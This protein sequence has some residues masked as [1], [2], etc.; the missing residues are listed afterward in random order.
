M[1]KCKGNL[2][3]IKEDFLFCNALPLTKKINCDK[4][5]RTCKK[6]YKMIKLVV[7]D[8]DGTLKPYGKACVSEKVIKYIDSA[9]EKGMTVA[10]SSGRT[11]SELIAFL[12]QFKDKIYFICSDGAYYIKSENILYER[13]IAMSDL[14]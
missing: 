12:P 10:V 2:L 5:N 3:G 9:I 7:I 4:M 1:N 14:S 6:R 11:Y 8:F 13:A